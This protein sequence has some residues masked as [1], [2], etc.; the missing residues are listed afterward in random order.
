ML[1]YS[2]P[3]IQEPLLKREW[4]ECRCID[5]DIFS[6]AMISTALVILGMSLYLNSE[7]YPANH[8]KNIE[9]EDKKYDI[10]G[11]VKSPLL[12]S[13]YVYGKINSSYI[14]SL[15]G[16]RNNGEGFR[17]TTGLTYIKIKSKYTSTLTTFF[18]F[19][20]KEQQKP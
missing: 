1:Q 13:D 19:Y 11:I 20:K 12:Y 7:H 16:I 3:T 4:T 18:R 10:I 8:I 17:K 14:L 9:L 15:E 6:K 2:L 5:S